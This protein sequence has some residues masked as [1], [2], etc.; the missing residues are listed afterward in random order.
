M[1]KTQSPDDYKV[2][3]TLSDADREKVKE[4]IERWSFKHYPNLNET[5]HD[6]YRGIIYKDIP[7]SGNDIRCLLREANSEKN[8]KELNKILLCIA[9]GILWCSEKELRE[10]NIIF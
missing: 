4:Y 3:V 10:A 1:T 8:S 5:F 7:L 2:I 6:L 9:K